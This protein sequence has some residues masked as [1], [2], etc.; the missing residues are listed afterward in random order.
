MSLEQA[1]HL[2]W[3]NDAPLAALVPITRVFTGK[4]VGSPVL[5]YVVLTRQATEPVEYTSSG[6]RIAKA[7]MRFDVVEDDLDDAKAT[8]IEMLRVFDRANFAMT[9][10]TVLNMQ[11][12]DQREAMHDD[13]SWC[14]SIEFDVTTQE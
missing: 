6:T 13:A 8:G 10:G 14:L 9:A 3:Q 1:I 7:V 11:L 5:P 4:A 12:R 2:R